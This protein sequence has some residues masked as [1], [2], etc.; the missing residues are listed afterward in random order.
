MCPAGLPGGNQ[1]KVVMARAL[2]LEPAIVLADE[3]AQG[4]DV[5]ARRAPPDPARGPGRRRSVVVAS[6]DAKELEACAT[7]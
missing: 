2:L 6:S 4:V 3:S 7:A 5:G 1:Q